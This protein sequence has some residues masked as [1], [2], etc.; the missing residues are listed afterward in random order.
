MLY[1]DVGEYNN[2]TLVSL[3]PTFV[4]PKPILTNLLSPSGGG[5]IQPR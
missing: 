1:R 3:G 2:E 4:F 5:P